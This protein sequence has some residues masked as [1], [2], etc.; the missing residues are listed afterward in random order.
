MDTASINPEQQPGK[1]ERQNRN[2]AK[3]NNFRRKQTIRNW[4]K[5][6]IPVCSLI[7][8]TIFGGGLY[9]FTAFLGS[10]ILL[11]AGLFFSFPAHKKS[12]HLHWYIG[13]ALILWL[14]FSLVPL[15][16]SFLGETRP[17]VNQK[18]RQKIT[19]LA[20]VYPHPEI[21]RLSDRNNRLQK[22]LEDSAEISLVKDAERLS[23]EDEKIAAGSLTLN[24]AGTVRFILLFAGAWMMM[25]LATAMN[26]PQRYWFMIVIVSG[27]AIVAALALLGR[28]VIDTGSNIWWFIPV[29]HR[30][31]GGGPFINRDHFASFCAL[32]T[33]LAFS[34]VIDPALGL[35]KKIENQREKKQKRISYSATQDSAATVNRNTGDTNTSRKNK[36]RRKKHRSATKRHRIIFAICLFILVSAT[37]MSFS[38]GGMIMMLIA[39]GITATFWLKG[40]PALATG[41]TLLAIFIICAFLFWPSSDVQQRIGTLQDFNAAMDY[42]TEM[43][44]EAVNQWKL[45]PITGSGAESFRTLNPLVRKIPS[46][47]TPLYAH[48]EYLQI[49]AETGIVGM[50]LFTALAVTFI[51]AVV[52]N[53]FRHKES[54]A[55]SKVLRGT[56]PH[57]DELTSKKMM[58][59][60]AIP[61]LPMIA[62]SAGAVSGMMLHMSADFPCRIPLNAFLFAGIAGLAMPLPVRSFSMR[63]RKWGWKNLVLGGIVAGFLLTWRADELQLDEP[64]YLK[65]AELPE[66]SRAVAYAPTYWV[67]WQKLSEKSRIQAQDA[68]YGGK[69]NAAENVDIEFEPYPLYQ[70]GVECLALATE[71]NPR[72]YRMWK[73]LTK[74]RKDMGVSDQEKIRQ[75]M[76]RMVELAPHRRGLWNNLFNYEKEQGNHNMLWDVAEKASRRSSEKIAGQLY[77]KIMKFEKERGNQEEALSAAKEASKLQP[78]KFPYWIKK[79]ELEQELDKLK[80]A[81]RSLEEAVQIKPKHWKTWLRLGKLRLEM[82]KDRSANEA[83][84]EAVKVKPDLRDKVDNIWQ[85]AKEK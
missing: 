14:L 24:Y 8:L 69:E 19:E 48:N 54:D 62:A 38:R 36:R 16:S 20:E 23:E 34:L 63:R 78:R 15:P 57:E 77:W 83:L 25:W 46:E 5:V 58:K 3:K 71:Y 49:L 64:S 26:G 67:P 51:G 22:E 61:P 18:S 28:Y 11:V 73:S 68:V 56:F 35:K 21:E 84:S 40:R 7:V 65:Q 72:D 53:I 59:H 1:T 9:P 85:K 33:P 74:A 79:A 12:T 42:R 81:E 27:G 30:R 82:N 76:H 52:K 39:I 37:I 43:Q 10:L 80:V 50:L 66:L 6:L 17:K 4:L 41:S 13:A 70:F 31:V 45:F 29:D 60:P 55:P 2:S 47:K 32:L 75:P 44:R